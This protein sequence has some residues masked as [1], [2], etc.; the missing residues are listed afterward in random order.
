MPV[1][2][3]CGDDDEEEGEEEL[4]ASRRAEKEAEQ[5]ISATEALHV[6]WR[7]PGVRRRHWVDKGQ[8]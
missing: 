4:H 6:D 8:P 7:V 1:D 2:K 3:L 5:R